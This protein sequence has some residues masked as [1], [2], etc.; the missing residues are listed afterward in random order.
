MK[1]PSRALFDLWS[2]FYDLPL[3]QRLAYWP[4]HEA[5]TAELRRRRP[6]AVL[7]LGCGTGQLGR[8][9]AATLPRARVVGCDFSSGMLRRAARTAP[10]R[11][12]WVGGHA[13]E[14]PFADQSFDVVVSTEAFHWFPDQRAALGEIRRVL[15][16]GGRL[17]LE[18]INPPFPFVGEMVLRTSSAVGEPFYW[19]TRASMRRRLGAAGF[20]VVEQRRIP[21]WVGEPLFPA[22]LTIARRTTATTP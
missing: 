21:R 1:G 16:P 19:P 7:D 3:V 9:I 4:V 13:G 22:V 18:L 8:R 5:V 12:A 17:L 6:R 20:R 14:L 15:V 10:S 2:T 11:V